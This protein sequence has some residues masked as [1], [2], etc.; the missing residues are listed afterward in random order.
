MKLLVFAHTPPPHHGQ[1]YMVQLMLEA[2][3]GDARASGG[4]AQRDIQCYHVDARLSKD[5]G[6]IGGVRVGKLLRLLAYCV[7]AIWCRFRYGI[8]AFYYI[9]A[10]AKHSAIYRDWIV[11]LLCRPFFPRLIL[12]WEA[13]GLGEW[14]SD[15]SRESAGWQQR[16]TGRLLAAAQLSVVPTNYNRGD[17][18]VFEPERIEVIANAIPDPMPDFET[19]LLPLRLS[20]LTN[21][22]NPD[23]SD[24]D[25]PRVFKLL[26]LAH[27]TREKGLYDAID[28]VALANAS[29]AQG[30]S[31]VRMH[32]TVAGTFMSMRDE[33]AFRLRVSAPDLHGEFAPSEGEC[34]IHY[35]GFV[36]GE[37]KQRLLF[38]SDCLCFPTYH[39]AE[40]QP[41][42]IIEALAFGL[43]IVTTR[44]RGVPEM[45]PAEVMFLTEPK[46]PTQVADGLLKAARFNEFP[47][48]R[49]HFLTTYHIDRFADR[50]ARSLLELPASR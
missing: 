28:A 2:F 13:F 48:A 25:V 33:E 11:M 46:T 40:A 43:P 37:Q 27:C 8:D 7:E 35:V 15:E 41:V 29:L 4:S 44:W 18:E 38:E 12:H 16:L 6:D 45:A 24:A 26:F 50:L 1:S 9:P 42:A 10:P 31:A 22:D 39:H 17:A 36:Q 32:L 23:G 20:R 5:L 14:A 30:H 19:Q 34:A 47:S 3:G 49:H 21:R